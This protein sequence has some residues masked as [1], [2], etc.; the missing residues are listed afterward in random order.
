MS[1]IAI[2]NMSFYS[3]HGCFKEEATI[4]TNFKVD[5]YLKCSTD[6]AE[7]SDNVED[8]VDYSAVYQLVK[9]QMKQPSHLLEAVARRII[10]S[11]KV[12]FPQVEGIK[13]KVTK[14]NPPLGGQIGGVSI[15][16]EDDRVDVL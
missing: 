10:E 15:T 11:I 8:T 5:L 16:I 12:S 6:K 14:L 9:K 13:V 4:G 3:Y 7:Q 2:E 1:I